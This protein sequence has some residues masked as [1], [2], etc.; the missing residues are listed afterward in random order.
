[1]KIR[2]ILLNKCV[3]NFNQVSI[4]EYMKSKM[5]LTRYKNYDGTWFQ[6]YHKVIVL[7]DKS[8]TKDRHIYKNS[9]LMKINNKIYNR[10][11]LNQGITKRPLRSF[12]DLK[13]YIRLSGK[14]FDAVDCYVGSAVISLDNNDEYK[15]IYKYKLLLDR[16]VMKRVI[17][18]I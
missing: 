2:N 4:N 7:R 8:L 10:V 5:L 3:I 18:N 1:M 15:D 17:T 12:T 14:V 11:I 6:L 13:R 9:H 16:S